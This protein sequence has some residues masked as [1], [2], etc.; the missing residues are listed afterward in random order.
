MKTVVVTGSQGFIG[1]YLCEELLRQ[2]YKV[3]GYD[4]FSKYGRVKRAHDDHPNFSLVE[5][6][7]RWV[8]PN[9]LYFAPEYII[10]GA[11]MIGGISY[12]HKYA[13][14]LLAANERIMANTVDAA[15]S[16]FELNMLKRLVVISSSMV[17]EGADSY[18]HLHNESLWPTDED[19]LLAMPPPDSTYGFQKLAA[20]YFCKGANEQYGLPYTIVRPFNCVG[21]GENESIQ[22]AEVYSGNVKL[23]MS[24]VL[25]DLVKK[26]LEGQDPLHILGEGNQIR[27]YTHGKDIARGIIDAMQS[28]EAI[29]TEFNIS[30]SRQTTVLELAEMVWKEVNGDKPFNVVVDPAYTYDVQRRIPNVSKARRRLGFEASITLEDSVRE[31]VNH[32]RKEYENNRT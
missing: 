14:D 19:S 26:C 15:L 27:C 7:L 24:H 29:N 13:Y 5:M 31:V 16:C 1:G 30:T 25:P 23:R 8:T 10:A 32:M 20:E 28:D 3:I 18:F 17:Y 22:D 6:D 2:G 9:F 12:F 11:A 4:N 21:I